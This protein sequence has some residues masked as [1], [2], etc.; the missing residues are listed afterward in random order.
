MMTKVQKNMVEAINQAHYVAMKDDDDVILLGQDIG[1]DGGVFRVTDGLLDEFGQDRVMDTP[2]AEAGIV[3]A[4]IGMALAGLKPICE[5][6]FSGFIYQTFHQIEQHMSRIRQRTRGRFHVPLVC[7]APYGGG[8]R[9]L[10]L[11]SESREAYFAHMPGIKM[12]IP[13]NP[14]DA[15][16][17]LLAAIKDPD[18]VI[19]YEPKKLYRAL[20]ED[21]PNEWYEVP[22]GKAKVVRQGKDVTL[23]GWGSSLTTCMEAAEQLAT[24]GLEAEVIDVRTIKPLDSDTIVTSV[25][26]TQ[27]AVVVHEAPRSFG[28][29]AEIVARLQRQAFLYLKAP[30]LRVTGYDVHIPYYALEEEYLPSVPK[31]V[32]AVR[33]ALSY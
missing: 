1:V 13:S 24:E 5:I 12:V 3:G 10:D 17:L 27:R 6:Q 4:S 30:V 31:I 8:I 2:L 20:R 21:V 14:Y 9:A 11:H 19:F 26:K 22:L 15:K 28:V 18:P 33:E 16:G 23:I 25:S 7:R 32:R 29:G